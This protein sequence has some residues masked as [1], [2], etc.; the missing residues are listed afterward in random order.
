MNIITNIITL[1]LGIYIYTDYVRQQ[2]EC[3]Q[4]FKDNP[5]QLVCVP[6]INWYAAGAALA[7]YAYGASEK[8]K[9]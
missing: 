9:K 4:K 8:K 6:S 5:N 2:K 3:D 7:I 1:G